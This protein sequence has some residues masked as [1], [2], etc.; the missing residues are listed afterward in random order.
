V[1][2]QTTQHVV[3]IQ[4]GT[5]YHTSQ[6]MKVFFETHADRLTIAQLPAYSP[7]FNPINRPVPERRQWAITLFYEPPNP[8]AVPTGE[9]RLEVWAVCTGQATGWQGEPSQKRR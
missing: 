1:L 6:A 9:V 4:D 2:S 8:A 3:V 5:R 7:A